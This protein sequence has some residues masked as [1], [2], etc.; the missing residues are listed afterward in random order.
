MRF[1]RKPNIIPITLSSTKA[2]G[3][4]AAGLVAT[5]KIGEVPKFDFPGHWNKPDVRGALIAIQR[6][7]CA[8]CLSERRYDELEVEHFRPKSSVA[9]EPTHGGYWWLAYHFQNYHLAC[10]TCNSTATKGSKFPLLAAPRVT[11][12]T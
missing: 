4:T 10:R 11:Y 6:R 3:I 7:T 9:E 1:F 5:Y 12:E 2:G 8:Y